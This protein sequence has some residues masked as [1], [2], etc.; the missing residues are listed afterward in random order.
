MND[1]YRLGDQFL[2][3]EVDDLDVNSL[4]ELKKF[5]YHFREKFAEILREVKELRL[6]Q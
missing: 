1:V 2:N 4:K 3:G 6:K 5:L